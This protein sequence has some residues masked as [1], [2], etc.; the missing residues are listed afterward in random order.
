LPQYMQY[1][2][3]IEYI[4]QI[5]NVFLSISACYSLVVGVKRWSTDVHSWKRLYIRGSQRGAHAPQGGNLIFKGGQFENELL[6]V[7]FLH[8][9]WF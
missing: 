3:H 9:L 8:F 5:E 2:Y 6:T 4:F 1:L 7:N